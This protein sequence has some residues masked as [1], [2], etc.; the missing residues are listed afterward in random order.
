[1]KILLGFKQII[2]CPKCNLKTAHIF[3]FGKK[4]HCYNCNHIWSLK[5]RGSQIFSNKMRLENV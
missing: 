4:A 5:W 3:N 2:S 1:M